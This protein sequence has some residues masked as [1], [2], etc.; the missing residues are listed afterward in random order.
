MYCSLLESEYIVNNLVIIQGIEVLLE[1]PNFH[2][3]RKF[4]LESTDWDALEIFQDILQVSDL[5]MLKLWT[6]ANLAMQIPHAFQQILSHEKIPTLCG[7]LPAFHAL[8]Q[9][10]EEYI[11]DNPE[12]AQVIQQGLDKLSEYNDCAES[13]LAY[14][15]AMGK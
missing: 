9:R 6:F 10:W 12:H 15:L 1:D 8:F 13:V 4:A 3:L 14:V 7:T 11:E 5:T 2:E